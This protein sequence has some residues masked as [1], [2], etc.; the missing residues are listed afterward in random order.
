M[1][2]QDFAWKKLPKNCCEYTTRQSLER[3]KQG[4]LLSG[5]KKPLVSDKGF[6]Q[7]FQH[8]VGTKP[9][10]YHSRINIWLY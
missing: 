6:S 4:Q 1:L 9:S 8:G 3:K 5:L 2:F 7:I 10:P